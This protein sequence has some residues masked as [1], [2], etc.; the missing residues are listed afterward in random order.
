MRHIDVT[1]RQQKKPTHEFS[2]TITWRPTLASMK[3]EAA[4]FGAV[5]AHILELLFDDEVKF[6]N[7][8]KKVLK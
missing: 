7:L 8:T 6:T 4:E 2:M 3:T 1:P 5:E